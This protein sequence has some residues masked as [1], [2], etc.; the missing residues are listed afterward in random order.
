MQVGVGETEALSQM[1]CLLAVTLMRQN[2][3]AILLRCARTPLH[4]YNLLVCCIIVII[5]FL[6]GRLNLT[7]I[8][9][10][11]RAILSRLYV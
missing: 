6:N 10:N 8:R 4:D 2:A 1:Y 11:S 9:A 3:R 7:L 5:I